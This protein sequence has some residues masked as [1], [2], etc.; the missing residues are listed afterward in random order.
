MCCVSGVV[1]LNVN[2]FIKA[3]IG[4]AFSILMGL[5]DKIN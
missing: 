1:I 3:S 2:A 5:K 4:E